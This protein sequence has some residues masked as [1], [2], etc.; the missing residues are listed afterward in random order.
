M[1][2]ADFL[3]LSNTKKYI[4]VKETFLYNHEFTQIKKAARFPNSLFLFYITSFYYQSM[5]Y[6]PLSSAIFMLQSSLPGL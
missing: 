5:T 6:Q 4:F 2:N 1:K 3:A